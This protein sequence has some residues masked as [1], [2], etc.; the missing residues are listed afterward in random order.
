MRGEINSGFRSGWISSE[1][2][3]AERQVKTFT[4]YPNSSGD[5]SSSKFL[6][7]TE[8]RYLFGNNIYVGADSSFELSFILLLEY[9]KFR[10]GRKEPFVVDYWYKNNTRQGIDFSLTYTTNGLLK[11]FFPDFFIK[12]KGK[13]LGIFE[14]KTSTWPIASDSRKRN[15]EPYGS[16]LERKSIALEQYCKSNGLE[17]GII[18][19]DTDSWLGAAKP[20]EFYIS[21]GNVRFENN[22]EHTKR[23]IIADKT[24]RLLDWLK[25]GD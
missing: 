18:H 13:P 5:T 23:C 25:G 24:S 17:Y 20:E 11:N 4:W 3:P 16:L 15:K 21:R 6:K 9:Y 8:D 22:L 7:R 10:K 2:N 12:F 14:V 1:E 19:C